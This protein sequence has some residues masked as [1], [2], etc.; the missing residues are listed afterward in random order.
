[1]C[2]RLRRGV[3]LLPCEGACF[4]LADYSAISSQ[5]DV[6][7]CRWLTTEAGVA[8]IPLS[9]FCE[10]LFPCTLIRLCFAK[11]PEALRG[12]VKSAAPACRLTLSGGESVAFSPAAAR[13][14]EPWVSV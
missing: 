13:V 3:K 12:A 9:V 2:R 6:A 14:F 1:M 7:F 5:D 11:Q 4:L 8:A 10:G